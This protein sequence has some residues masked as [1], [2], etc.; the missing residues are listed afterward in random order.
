LI[1]VD[2]RNDNIDAQGEVQGQIE[3]GALGPEKI[4][5]RLIGVQYWELFRFVSVIEWDNL[6]A[7]IVL[8]SQ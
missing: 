7:L 2:S 8:S 4:D 3:Q 1:V 6:I 5:T